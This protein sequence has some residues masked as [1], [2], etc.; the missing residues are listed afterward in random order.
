MIPF[1][2]RLIREKNRIY[3]VILRVLYKIDYDSS[4][5]YLFH[6]LVDDKTTIKSKF[7][8]SVN[9][10]ELFLHNQIKAGK[11]PIN[12]EELK[13]VIISRDRIKNAFIVSFDD[14]NESVFLKAYPILKRLNI[15]FIIFITVELIGKENY[16]SESQIKQLLKDPLC[17]L[18]SHG[19]HHKMFRYLTEVQVMNELLESKKYLQNTFNAKIDCFA[20][21]Y[22]RIV[23]C[24]F[25]NMKQL[26]NSEYL[27]SFSAISGHLGQSWLTSNYFLP[28]IN[29]SEEE[30]SSLYMK[31]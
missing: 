11:S 7:T 18:G 10:F 12:F 4:R 26:S 17:I 16:L 14:A 8:I 30:V 1:K 21:P 27:F 31:L 9:S 3:S 23:E 29:V 2:L 22:G 28:R 19:Y 25:R 20:F 13:S 15:P 6:D 5:V 24:S